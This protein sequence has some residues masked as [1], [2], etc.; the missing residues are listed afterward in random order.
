MTKNR[1]NKD[2]KD[3]IEKDEDLTKDSAKSAQPDTSDHQETD[4]QPQE[5]NTVEAD[6]KADGP[7]E[8]DA[9]EEKYLRLMADF[10]NFRKR[11]DKEKADIYAFGN[12]KLVKGM[13]PVID[14]FERALEAAEG[15]SGAEGFTEGMELIL[16]QLWQ[17]LEQAGVEEVKAEGCEFDPN[18]H[19]AVLMEASEEH[20]SGYVTTVLQK[21]YMLN[22]RVLRPSMVKVAE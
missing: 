9:F 16:K 4:N 20:K 11:Q 6:A 19:N 7:K 15:A 5:D 22:G 12:E 3:K 18:Y 8:E 17:V 1:E 10:Q 14:N 2:L 21:G 13:L